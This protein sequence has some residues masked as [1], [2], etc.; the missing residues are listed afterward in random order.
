VIS[1]KKKP[2]NGRRFEILCHDLKKKNLM[3]LI[4]LTDTLFRRDEE[5]QAY[6]LWKKAGDPAAY[7]SMGTFSDERRREGSVRT[8]EEERGERKN[9]KFSLPGFIY[10]DG[11]V[12][13]KDEKKAVKCWRGGAERD[14]VDCITQLGYCYSSGSCG[15]SR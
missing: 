13:P 11:N 7:Y 1:H 2:E 14:N 8:G 9:K 10:A 3:C 5:L 6:T 15:I 4:S 12:I